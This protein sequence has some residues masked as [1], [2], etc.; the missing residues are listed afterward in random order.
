MNFISIFVVGKK[1]TIFS[2]EPMLKVKKYS[3]R[4]PSL[5]KQQLAATYWC[6][7][8]NHYCYKINASLFD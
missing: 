4:P 6:Y 3:R 1:L 7:K 5:I 2:K 8:E